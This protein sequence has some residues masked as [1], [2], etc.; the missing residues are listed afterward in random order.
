MTANANTNRKNGISKQRSRNNIVEL[1]VNVPSE[2]AYTPN[3]KGQ[4]QQGQKSIEIKNGKGEKKR[5]N[6]K[7]E[8]ER[9][10]GSK[11]GDDA[12]HN[13]SAAVAMAVSHATVP[14]WMNT[15]LMVS[16]IFGGCCSNVCT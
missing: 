3:P 6:K 2:D 16:L 9:G 1:P 13:S 12:H 14:N 8:K 15:I 4:S 5:K 10:K 11:D 7:N